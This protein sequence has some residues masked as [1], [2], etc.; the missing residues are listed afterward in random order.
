[1]PPR[2]LQLLWGLVWLNCGWGRPSKLR[3]LHE[4]NREYTSA[5]VDLAK[6]LDAANRKLEL[7]RVE[8]DKEILELKIQHAEETREYDLAGAPGDARGFGKTQDQA[9]RR[10]EHLH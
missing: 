10:R 3:G 1:M 5:S 4:D 7:Q 6:K 2:C 9:G 8:Y